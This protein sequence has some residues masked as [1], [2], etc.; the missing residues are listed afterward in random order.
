VEVAI[1]ETTND[2][3][4]DL[5]KCHDRYLLPYGGGGSGKSHE[6]AQKLLLRIQKAEKM[7][8]QEGFLCV[9][10][11]SVS[12]K[13]S[14]FAL[15]L[16]YIDLWGLVGVKVNKSDLSLTWPGGSF[17][18]CSGLDDPEKVKSIERITG[19]WMEEATECT[20]ADFRQLD[21][22]LRGEAPSYFQIIMTFNPMDDTSWLND[23]FFNPEA[24]PKLET[25]NDGKCFRIKRVIEVPELNKHLE[26]YATV[27]HSTW[28]DNK[29]VDEQ[30]VAMLATLKERDPERYSIY[31]QGLWTALAERIYANYT[32][33]ADKDWPD[34]FDDVWYGLDIGFNSPTAL[35]EC[36]SLD[37]DIYEREMIYEKG[38]H[39]DDIIGRMRDLEIDS[40]ADIYADPS[41]AKEI[42][43][44]YKAGFNISKA[45][46]SVESG[47]RFV[48]AIH[49]RIHTGS[50]NHLRE[51]KSYKYKQDKNGNIK[52]VP[53]KE[54]DHAQD[55]ER[56]ALFTHLTKDKSDIWFV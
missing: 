30:Y 43:L 2:Q 25:W 11:T 48:R 33:V 16:D 13:Q 14:V 22:R 18:I 47:I 40:N 4:V 35:I 9:R 36:C 39:T 53:V 20:L 50:V 56:Y 10:K 42:D 3:L 5:I 55:A 6:I 37:G 46:N 23:E 21:L 27:I 51:K 8:Y 15:C 52:E 7:G 49:L 44:I 29:W 45:D 41:A 19:I 38:L 26:V 54:N 12:V 1:A 34:A 31:D 32:E 24:A 28:R 17:I